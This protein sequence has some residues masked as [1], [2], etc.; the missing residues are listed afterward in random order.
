MALAKCPHCGSLTPAEIC[1]CC[2][3]DR[4]QFAFSGVDADASP[5]FKPCENKQGI[6]KVRL[7]G[8][9]GCCYGCGQP[10]TTPQS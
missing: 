4:D 7:A 9:Q 10:L 5:L 1:E 3:A 6:C 8:E 2:G